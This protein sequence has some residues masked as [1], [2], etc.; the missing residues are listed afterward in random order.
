LAERE[1]KMRYTPKH[2][3]IVEPMLG[4]GQRTDGD[5]G[6]ASKGVSW[7]T[8]LLAAVLLCGGSLAYGQNPKNKKDR[9]K[10]DTDATAASLLPD[11]SAIDLLVTQML[12][13]WQA[14]DAEA[15]HKFYTDDV[16]VVSG[17]WEPPLFGWTNYAAAYRAQMA[18]ATG[19]RLE[20][21]NSFIKVM[22]DTAWVTYQWQYIGNVAG[23]TI[24]AFGHTTLVLQKR[25]G[26]WLIV[27]NHTSAIPTDTQPAQSSTAPA[28]GQ[29]TSSLRPDAK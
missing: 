9:N 16:A 21:T 17:G 3:S 14:G 27:L 20:R 12:G 23:K 24:Q 10:N 8:I 4:F 18:Q 29:A 26:T 2:I 7:I 11:N 6:R 5:R 28:D 19:S 1:G 15:M 25:A 22:G 13:A